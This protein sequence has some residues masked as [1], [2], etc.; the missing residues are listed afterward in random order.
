MALES[1]PVV[2]NLTSV[3]QGEHLEAARIGQD[4]PGQHMNLCSPAHIGDQF[5]AG[6]EVQVIRIS[7]DQAGAEVTQLL[8]CERFDRRL[9]AN[10]G[11]HRGVNLSM[12]RLEYT[13]SRP[14]LA[15]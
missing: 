10:R 5:V 4:G 1:Y 8:G 13:R 11:E 9:G 3:G 14:A 12:R 2:V 15:V 6:A 7:Q